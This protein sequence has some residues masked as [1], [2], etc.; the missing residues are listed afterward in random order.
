M[1]P[2]KQQNN[3]DEGRWD[4]QHSWERKTL[5]PLC[6]TPNNT[7]RI[8]RCGFLLFTTNF[9]STSSQNRLYYKTIGLEELDVNLFHFNFEGRVFRS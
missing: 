1:T 4:N 6:M 7:S 3:K 8:I 2:N 5:L 9:R